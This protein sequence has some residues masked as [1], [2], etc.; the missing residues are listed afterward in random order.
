MDMRTDYATRANFCKIL[1]RDTKPLYLLA[2][3]LTANH[4]A[5]EHCFIVAD[6]NVPCERYSFNFG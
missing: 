2:F 4:E 5:A 6:E 1:V 3:I